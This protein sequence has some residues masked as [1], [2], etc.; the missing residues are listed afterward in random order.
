MPFRRQLNHL[1]VKAT[2]VTTLITSRTELAMT[3][4][5]SKTLFLKKKLFG[6][7][8]RERVMPPM[9]AVIADRLHN[10]LVAEI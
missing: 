3:L 1:L 10:Q 2:M 5:T 6:C 4:T 7:M 8:A 9:E